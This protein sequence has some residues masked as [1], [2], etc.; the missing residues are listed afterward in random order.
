MKQPLYFSYEDADRFSRI[1]TVDTDDSPALQ[2][3][4]IR[5]HIARFDAYAP[6]MVLH[7]VERDGVVEVTGRRRRETVDED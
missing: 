5:R 1:G 7:R 6:R 3:R 2:D 4:A